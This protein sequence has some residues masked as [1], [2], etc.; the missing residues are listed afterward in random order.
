MTVLGASLLA[1]VGWGVGYGP[2]MLLPSLL[3]HGWDMVGLSSAISFHILCSALCSLYMANAHRRFGVSVI[4]VMGAVLAGGGLIGWTTASV[5]WHLALVAAMT[6]VGWS[7]FG[8]AA[9][10][11]MMTNAEDSSAG[12]LARALNGVSVGGIVFAPLWTLL[13]SS[14]GARD[15]ASMIAAIGLLIAIPASLGATSVRGASPATFVVPAGRSR[16]AILGERSMKL[17]MAA[18]ACSVIA[19]M[20]VFLHLP[21]YLEARVGLPITGVLMSV[22]TTAAVAGRLALARA[23]RYMPALFLTAGCFCTMSAA[24]GL[25]WWGQSTGIA[26]LSLGCAVFGCGVGGLNLLPAMVARTQFPPEDCAAAV[27]ILSAGNLAA[28]AIAPVVMGL[29]IS[30]GGMRLAFTAGMGEL[31]C[32]ALL[33]G[34]ASASPPA[35]QSI[36]HRA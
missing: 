28:L 9:L 31:I 20:G 2:S 14:T 17:S 22:T 3:A 35:H 7:A 12:S 18:F 36:I 21:T 32:A 23:N 19:V 6:G 5:G 29:L 27:G 33:C 34:L 11:S 13:I 4:S 24:L 26:G 15:A 8:T 10:N 25:L 30:G 1:G 16:R